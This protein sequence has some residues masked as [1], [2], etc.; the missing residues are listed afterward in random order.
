MIGFDPVARRSTAQIAAES[1]REQRL[2]DTLG[3]KAREVIRNSP[4]HADFKIAYAI[5]RFRDTVYDCDND[6]CVRHV[7]LLSPEGD[8]RF[9][10]YVKSIIGDA[11][12]KPYDKGLLRTQLEPPKRM[13][14][15][16]LA[17]PKRSRR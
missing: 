15:R 5:R 3:P 14:G 4:H 1:D 16:C 8:A 17:L 12:R 6:G 2:Y 7:D 9:A 10:Q 13:R 11:I